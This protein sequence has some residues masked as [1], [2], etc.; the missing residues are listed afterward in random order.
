MYVLMKKSKKNHESQADDEARN[1]VSSTLHGGQ[2]Q[3]KFAMRCQLRSRLY[4][5]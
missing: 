5:N 1:F 2:V 3:K 4:I